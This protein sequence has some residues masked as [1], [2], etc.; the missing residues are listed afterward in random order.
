MV[1][2]MTQILTTK[3]NIQTNNQFIIKHLYFFYK[4]IQKKFVDYV[5]FYTFA[6]YLG[7]RSVKQLINGNDEKN[8]RHISIGNGG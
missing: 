4:K 3:K 8:T 1:F 5:T 7:E 6:T 2:H